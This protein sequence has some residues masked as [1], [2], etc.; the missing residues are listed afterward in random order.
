MI[1]YTS[2][3]LAAIAMSS[4]DGRIGSFTNLMG[5]AF[6]RAGKDFGK[7]SKK[8]IKAELKKKKK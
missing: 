3:V 5:D 1:H 2:V 4:K 6:E 8:M 7:Y